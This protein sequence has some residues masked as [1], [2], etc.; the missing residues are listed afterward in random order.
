RMMKHQPWATNGEWWLPDQPQQRG[1]GVLRF[2]P[3]LGLTPTGVVALWFVFD[4]A[5][6][7]GVFPPAPCVI[8]GL[9]DSGERYTCVRN[10]FAHISQNGLPGGDVVTVADIDTQTVLKG[11]H[12]LALISRTVRQG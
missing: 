8:L 12:G 2:D 9:A 6:L 7:Q 10:F 5:A 1:R 11:Q 3:I 4:P